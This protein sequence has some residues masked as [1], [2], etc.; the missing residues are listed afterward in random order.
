L[1]A[2]LFFGIKRV[3]ESPFFYMGFFYFGAAE[4]FPGADVVGAVDGGLHDGGVVEKGV[5]VPGEEL[6]LVGGE[7]GVDLA[8]ACLG[9]F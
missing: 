1:D 9:H 5:V 6:R 3:L 2:F 4:D 8:L 7:G